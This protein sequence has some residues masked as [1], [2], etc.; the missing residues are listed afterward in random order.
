MRFFGLQDVDMGYSTSMRILFSCLLVGALGVPR[1]TSSESADASVVRGMTISCQ[2]WGWEWGS[3]GF[4]GELQELDELGVNWV[5]IHPYARIRKDGSVSYR[6]ID[7][8]NPPKHLAGAIQTAHERGLSILIKPHL[9]YWGSGFSWRGEIK[10]DDPTALANFH[11]SYAKWITTLAEVTRDADAFCVGTELEGLVASPEPWRKLIAQVRKK[12]DAHLTYAANWSEY[13]LVGFW[14]ALDVIGLQAYFPISETS[15]PTERDLHRGWTTVLDEL[16][17]LHE[18]WSKPIVFT[19][20]GYNQSLTAAAKPWDYTRA[21]GK[22]VRPA[23]ELQARCTKVA[24]E[25]LGEERDWLR[26]VFLWKWFVGEA[27]G[28]NFLVDTP[29]LRRVLRDQW[30]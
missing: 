10:F 29:E 3:P 7:L 11:K 6:E 16:E 4:A 27:P 15:S 12:T 30:R 19:E 17:A 1:A 9:A 22:D 14:D 21:R 5:A 2:T 24:L 20:L 23:S 28:E 13:E 8:E 18:K 26:G 25:V